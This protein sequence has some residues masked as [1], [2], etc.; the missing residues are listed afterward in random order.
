M[1]KFTVLGALFIILLLTLISVFSVVGKESDIQKCKVF[2]EGYG[3]QTADIPTDSVE[4]TV[5]EVFDNVYTRYNA[6]QQSAGLDLSP[7]C[8][9]SGLRYTFTVTNY[10]ADI[11]ETV[12]ANV[13]IIDGTAVGGDIMTVS[14]NGFMHALNENQPR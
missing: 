6:I 1:K 8:G 10:P 4:I 13:L 12:Y 7:F 14:L 5:P 9:K 2:L 11:G 3:W